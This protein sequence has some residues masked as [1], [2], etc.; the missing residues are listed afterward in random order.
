[1]LYPKQVSHF[2][3]KAGYLMYI[4]EQLP[5]IPQ[6]RIVVKTPN[7]PAANALKRADISGI[8]WPRI[9]R[10]SSIEELVG[11]E[12][13]FLTVPDLHQ[14]TP[15]LAGRID[16]VQNSAGDLGKLLG[17]DLPEKINVIIA[18]EVNSKSKGAYIGNP[19]NDG[20]IVSFRIYDQSD[21][22]TFFYKSGKLEPLWDYTGFADESSLDNVK[23]IPKWFESIYSLP[24]IDKS[25][26]YKMEFS[27]NPLCL[28]QF[29]PFKEKEKPGFEI[30]DTSGAYIIGSTSKNGIVGRLNTNIGGILYNG[31]PHDDP[32]IICEGIRDMKIMKYLSKH[33]EV[34][35]KFEEQHIANIFTSAVGVTAHEDVKLLRLAK[36]SLLYFNG[37]AG[38]EINNGDM[39]KIISDGN[40]AQITKL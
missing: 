24:E 37:H 25:F 27:L 36:T 31:I 29:S 18:N 5:D 12:G 23:E 20:G 19:N 16:Q 32:I 7:E 40:H 3:A 22:C 8:P 9:F 34:K 30:D 35:K 38:L 10:S 28:F 26:S 17:L 21:H 33:P 2:G 4:K 14:Y 39:I 6:A 11:F 15:N 13:D 1:M